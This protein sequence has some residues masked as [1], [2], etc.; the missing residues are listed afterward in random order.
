[1]FVYVSTLAG[2]PPPS[3][4]DLAWF[5]LAGLLLPLWAGWADRH[6]DAPPGG[7]GVTR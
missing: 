6:R 3:T 5:G 1:V 4:R 7:G 2:P